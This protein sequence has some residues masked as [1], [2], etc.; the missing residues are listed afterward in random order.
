MNV[1]EELQNPQ[2]AERLMMLFCEGYNEWLCDEMIDD[3]KEHE[4]CVEKCKY[5]SPID[6]C[7]IRYIKMKFRHE[8]KEC[9]KM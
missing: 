9:E 4:E 2:V 3:K 5:S 1:R 8:G 6:E 7:V